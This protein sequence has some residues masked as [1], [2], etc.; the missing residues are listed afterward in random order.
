MGSGEIAPSMTK[1]HRQLLG[2]LNDVRAI[3]MDTPYGFQA[4]VP[5]MTEKIIDY[6]STSLGVVIKPLY[7]T[8]FED[9]S[10][11]EK[12]IFRQ[13]VIEAN[14][15]FAGPGSPTYAVKQWAPLAFGDN[16]RT[17]LATEG[18]VCFASAAALTLG[19][20]TAPIYEIYKVGDRP[21]W[22]DGLDVLSMAGIRAAII[23]HYDNAEGGNYD[24]RYCYLGEDRLVELER[25]LPDDL[26]ILGIDEHT[27]CVIDLEEKTLQVLGKNN[28]Y[29]RQMGQ[30]QVFANGSISNLDAIQSFEPTLVT[31][32]D[33]RI[34][35]STDIESLVVAASG[36]GSESVD[37][38]AK[39]ARL[40]T[41]G[42][43]NFVDPTTLVTSLLDL[44][45]TARNNHEFT[46]ADQIRNLLIDA[47]IEVMDGPN[48]STWALK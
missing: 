22:I 2:R 31:S 11:V 9:A 17:T 18:I 33:T 8:S 25:Q 30:T 7:Y 32:I 4:N 38:I 28:V 23:P 24:T 13:E 34:G 12:A 48:G 16:L 19:A 41:T 37:A 39:L 6:F 1:V 3:S 10:E 42:G 14:Y 29:W 20:R 36:T 45:L 47:G 21:E 35:A 46:L 44:R 26:G 27:A 5:Q 43:S 15:V 40:A